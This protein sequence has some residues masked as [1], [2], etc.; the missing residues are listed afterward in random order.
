MA[1]WQLENTLKEGLFGVIEQAEFEEVIDCFGIGDASHFRGQK[2]LF[3]LRREIKAPAVGGI[4][5]GFDAKA[6]ARAEQLLPRPVPNG[7]TPHAVEALNAIF[8]PLLV[9]MQDN[10]RVGPS[11]E[12]VAKGFQ[13][14]A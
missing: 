4:V 12:P 5:E 14:S 6:V 2:N 10:F 11:L 1:T 8:A 7:K 3:D 9:G 13:F